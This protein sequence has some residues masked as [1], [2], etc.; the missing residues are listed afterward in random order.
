MSKLSTLKEWF[1]ISDAAKHLTKKLDEEV[2][3]ADVLKLGIDRHLTLSVYFVNSTYGAIGRIEEQSERRR[4]LHEIFEELRPLELTEIEMMDKRMT[5]LRE[6]AGEAEKVNIVQLEGVWD[7]SMIGGEV[8]DVEHAQMQLIGGP[9]VT[10][11]CIDGS[12]VQNLDGIIYELK[13]RFDEKSVR[14]QRGIPGHKREDEF[15]PAGG[16]PEDSVLV[17]RPD[18]LN[19]F[20]TRLKGEE[21][22]PKDKNASALGDCRTWT[23]ESS[24][25][26]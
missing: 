1:T 25:G 5:L 9:D 12:F 24:V 13:T 26:G 16:L 15:H 8:L 10:S 17:V 23:P 7:L 6:R 14:K 11:V 21:N 18:E 19:A 20:V 22:G 2:N 4:I 3:E